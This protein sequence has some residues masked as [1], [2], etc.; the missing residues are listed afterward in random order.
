MAA[1]VRRLSSE[2]SVTNWTNAW[3]SRRLAGMPRTM[4]GAD[5]GVSRTVLLWHT[6]QFNPTWSMPR[7]RRLETPIG[8][9]L[10]AS[11][12]KPNVAYPLGSLSLQMDGSDLNTQYGGSAPP[13]GASRLPPCSLPIDPYLKCSSIDW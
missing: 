4:R 10:P 5:V 1:A 9:S 11:V 8:R 2:H 12:M 3:R 7:R 6:A 13:T